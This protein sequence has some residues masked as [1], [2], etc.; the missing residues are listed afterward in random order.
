LKDFE[1]TWPHV[2]GQ[3]VQEDMGVDADDVEDAGEK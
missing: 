3:A 2:V 1:K